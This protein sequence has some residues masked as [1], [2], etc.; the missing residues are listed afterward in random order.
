MNS[1]A[2]PRASEAAPLN[3]N[4]FSPT[5]GVG[6]GPCDHCAGTGAVDC[7]C[8]D[9]EPDEL[10]AKV[11]CPHCNGPV[12][13][14]SGERSGGGLAE[15]LVVSISNS[16]HITAKIGDDELVQVENWIAPRVGT[17]EPH[18]TARAASFNLAAALSLDDGGKE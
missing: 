9:C 4:T 10:P 18:A 1:Q 16:G 14:P 3:Q 17:H 11:P 6:E 13:A 15:E 12:A 2:T 8:H 5:K 7:E